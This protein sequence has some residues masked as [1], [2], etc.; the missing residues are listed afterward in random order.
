MK[1]S[2]F[3]QNAHLMLK[4]YTIVNFK[5]IFVS[6]LINIAILSISIVAVY[7]NIG[8]LEFQMQWDDYWVVINKFTDSGFQTENVYNVLSEFYHGQYSPVN[9]LYYITIKTI[10]GYDPF[11][12]HI[13]SLFIHLIDTLLVYSFIGRICKRYFFKEIKSSWNVPLKTA[14]I[15]GIHPINSEAVA[16]IA[17]SKIPL[18]ACFYLISIHFYLYYLDKKGVKYILLTLLF[19]IISFGA[20]EQAVT[21][22]LTLL[23]LDYLEKRNLTCNKVILEKIIFFSLS[24]CFGIITIQSQGQVSSGYFDEYNIFERLPLS[25]FTLNEY[26]CK[27]LIPINL[28]YVYPFPFSPGEKIPLWLWLYP[29]GYLTM[30]ILIWKN[31]SSSRVVNFASAFSLVHIAVAL[32]LFSLTRHSLIADRYAYLFVIAIAFLLIFLSHNVAEMFYRQQQLTFGVYIYAVLLATYT[33]ARIPVW[34]NSKSL[35]KD[36]SE[37]IKNRED[38]KLLERLY[39]DQ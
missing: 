19:Y 11:Y 23:L 22:P 13:S 26:V 36:V 17:A 38:Y 37:K 34:Q 21:L 27:A 12:F 30:I 8:K 16:W 10:W 24:I 35:K 28:C 15:F 3:S 29:A 25:I 39:E 2:I 14:L 31:I 33:Y 6:H 9:E 4:L 32:N 20:K 1:S 7:R 5:N 18:Y